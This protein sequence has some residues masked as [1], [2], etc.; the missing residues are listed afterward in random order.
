[1]KELLNAELAEVNIVIELMRL[2]IE[3]DSHLLNQLTRSDFNWMKSAPLISIVNKL[4]LHGPVEP[5]ECAYCHISTLQKKLMQVIFENRSLACVLEGFFT[6]TL[7]RQSLEKNRESHHARV[8]DLLH[9][10]DRRKRKDQCQ[11]C[12]HFELSWEAPKD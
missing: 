6:L 3:G 11:D 12:H 4:F 8:Q 9:E 1:M 2:W 10:V 7:Q 5:I